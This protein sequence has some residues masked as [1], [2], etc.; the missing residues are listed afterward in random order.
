[1]A[2]YKR[3]RGFDVRFLTG[4]DEHGQK[5]EEKAK[6]AGMASTTY[7][8]EIAAAKEVMGN[9]GYHL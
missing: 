5:I 7:V 9:D 1:M 8:D 6:E 2:R 4:M 3:R